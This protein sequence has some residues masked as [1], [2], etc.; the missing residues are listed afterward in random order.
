MSGSVW[1]V[2]L[3]QLL[4]VAWNLD[5]SSACNRQL[6]P[7][8]PRLL[9]AK[10]LFGEAVRACKNEMVQLIR[11]IPPQHLG[12]LVIFSC[13][14]YNACKDSLEANLRTP[15]I[16]MFPCFMKKVEDTGKFANTKFNLSESSLSDARNV[17]LCLQKQDTEKFDLQTVDDIMAFGRMVILTYGWT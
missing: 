7:I 10:A 15:L 12:K 8:G 6:P 3:A 14:N 16:E 11:K 5:C 4:F 2:M 13:A 1:C 9:R 17:L